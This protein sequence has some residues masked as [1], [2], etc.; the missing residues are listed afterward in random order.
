MSGIKWLDF[1]IAGA[2]MQRKKVELYLCSGVEGGFGIKVDGKIFARN[3][4]W[5]CFEEEIKEAKP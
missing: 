2:L 1:V 4:A 5:E 3:L